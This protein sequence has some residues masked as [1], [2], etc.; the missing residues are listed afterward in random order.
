MWWWK[1]PRE[2]SHSSQSSSG[3]LKLYFLSSSG[4]AAGA[5]SA[6]LMAAA[7]SA[8][9]YGRGRGYHKG[10]TP[11]RDALLCGKTRRNRHGRLLGHVQVAQ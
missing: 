11:P 3:L 5:A 7:R 4:A 2:G 10:H 6:L 9:G 1:E 8:L